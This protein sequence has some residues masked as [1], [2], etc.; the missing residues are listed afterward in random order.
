MLKTLKIRP[1]LFWDIDPEILSEENNRTLIIERVTN[2]GNLLEWK[3][4][5]EFYGIDTIKLELM[6]A[7]DLYPKTIAFVE[8]YLNIP[9]TSLKCYTRKQLNQ[10]HWNL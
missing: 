8:S 6:K 9:K 4:I 2:L 5:V 10:P 1:S 3:Q 7:G